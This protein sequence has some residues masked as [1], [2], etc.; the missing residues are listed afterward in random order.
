VNTIKKIHGEKVNLRIVTRADALNIYHNISDKD[1][2]RFTHIPDPYKL[3][4]AYDFIKLT[5]RQRRKKTAFH[6]GLE[7]RDN[8][9]IIGG[10]GLENISEIHRKGEIGYWLG[11]TFWGKGIMVEA[12]NLM[13]DF[14]FTKVKLHR[15]QAYVFPDNAGSI[16]VLEKTGFK[17]E[18]LI[19]EG[20][21][22]RGKHVDVYLY[23]ILEDEWA[24]RDLPPDPHRSA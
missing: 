4:D 5:H 3:E 2:S 8:G 15:V 18:G 17:R 13:L 22:Q 23:A 9:Q 11:K 24:R 1:I 14:C 16:R 10:I 12:I 19:R 21:T 6:F 7:N 20:F